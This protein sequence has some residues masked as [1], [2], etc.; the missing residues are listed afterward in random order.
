MALLFAMGGTGGLWAPPASAQLPGLPQLESEDL[1][2]SET[3]AVD[4]QAPTVEQEEIDR[5]FA[6]ALSLFTGE[7]R[8]ASLTVFGHVAEILE[9]QRATGGLEAPE[10]DMLVRCLGYR[11]WV[12]H[13]LEMQ[14]L[15][16]P[17]L[18]RILEVDPGASL[19]LLT[20]RPDFGDLSPDPTAPAADGGEAETVP[21]KLAD[22]FGKLRKKTIGEV[23]FVVSPLDAEILIDGEPVAD[24]ASPVAVPAGTRGLTIRRPGYLPVEQELE[25][26]AGKTLP[27]E[28]EMER[29]SAILRLNTR[30]KEAEIRLD[31]RLLG[32]TSG[33]AA[34]GFLPQGAAALYRREEFSGEMIVED[35]E[36][37]LRILEISK[38][39][40]RPYR[41][42][43]AIQELIDYQMPP[44]VLEAQ[45]GQLVFVDFPRGADIFIDGEKT[46]A[47]VP[48]VTRP[49]LSLAPGDYH[50]TVT[51]GSTRMFSTRLSLADR[52]NVEVRV[53][54][55]PGLS[56]LGVLGADRTAARNLRQSFGLAAKRS[57]KWTLIDRSPEGPDVLRRAGLDAERLRDPGNAVDWRAVQQ[58]LDRSA[59]GLLYLLAVLDN[60]LVAAEA[61][62]WILTAGPGPAKPDRVVLPLGNDPALADLQSRLDE[63]LVLYRPYTG[64]VAIDSG[65]TANPV[66][67]HLVPGSPGE[68]A[69]L[70]PG[71]EI[72]GVDGVTVQSRSELE[73]RFLA[74]E[75][76]ETLELVV[77]RAGVG[78]S[79][80]LTLTSGPRLLDPAEGFLPTVAYTELVL[81]E[82]KAER[83]ERWILQLNRALLLMG[84]GEHEAAAKLLRGIRGPQASHGMNQ[85]TV[86]YHLGLALLRSGRSEVESA[87][88]Q[89]FE[90]AMRLPGARLEHGDGAFLL[91]RVR[92]RLRELGPG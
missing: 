21:K 32:V 39:G 90:R 72:L 26:Q 55:R 64:I 45:G 85:G 53:E 86:D 49:R 79:E 66:V 28:L 83:D 73:Q 63:S 42:E 37:G 60:D 71:D 40:F 38:P 81:L 2:E 87:A 58:V 14:D 52:Q 78:R 12:H 62:F 31:G 54:L 27:F 16:E 65:A 61:T 89:A 7:D 24:P 19:D 15:V 3:L 84:A 77:R 91:P 76:G 10:K 75:S 44:I 34:E 8:P 80:R 56:F 13:E 43:L 57:S 29:S 48:G 33:T 88:R 30:P 74:S 23:A 35:L 59:P 25:V 9:A 4:V 11:A 36:P 18:V 69:N 5:L 20:V 46:E 67:A 47:D 22:A 17:T 92:A 51:S 82:E 70:R 41:M 50:V 1:D 6:E 68:T